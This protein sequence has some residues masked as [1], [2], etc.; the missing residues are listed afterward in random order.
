MGIAGSATAT[1]IAQV[2]TLVALIFLLYRSK[3]FLPIQRAGD[4]LPHRPRD[5]ARAGRQGPADGPADDRDVAVD[6]RDDLRSSTVSART[7][8]RPTARVSSC[9]TTSRCRRSRSAWPRRRWP[10]RTSARGRWDRVT[11]IAL[12]GVGFNFL[13]TGSLVVTVYLFNRGAL[14]LFLPGDR[15]RDRD[16]AA[17]Q[18]DRGVVVRVLRRVVRDRRRRALDRR[19]DS[20]ADHP[21][22]RAV[23]GAHSVRVRFRRHAGARMRSGGASR[24]ARSCR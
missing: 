9:G 1:L 14:G 12:T 15:R 2:V 7:R 3:H 13:L 8:P 21:R 16:R 11:R 17:H 22:H 20:A 5:P 19:G 24:S 10:R 18:C 4:L 6:D 23:A